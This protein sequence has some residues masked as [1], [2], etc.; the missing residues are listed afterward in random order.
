MHFFRYIFLTLLY[1]GDLSALTL[2]PHYETQG[3]DIHAS[4]IYKDVPKDF[5]LF[6]YD[7]NEYIYHSNQTEISQI[8]K[9]HGLTLKFDGARYIT[10]Q[11]K[12]TIDLQPIIKLL[13]Q[14]FTSKYPNINIKALKVFPRAYLTSLPK[15]YSLKLQRQNLYQNHSTFA[16]VTP[17]HKMYFFDYTLDATLN[18]IVTT[19]KIQRHEQLGVSNTREKNV[20]FLNFKGMPLCDTTNHQYQSKF[21]LKSDYI[22]TQNDVEALSVVHRND[23]VNA[24]IEDG[25]VS[26]SFEAVAEED[27]KVGDTITIR[28]QNGKELRAK[29]V[30][31]NR[32]EIE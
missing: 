21:S 16:I 9:K 31:M 1:I 3:R 14:E 32:V 13:T 12:S 15:E 25:R 28:K 10:F 18:V 4:E 22:L 17:D 8:F 11:Q 20:Q 2:Q 29:V 24:F 27:G 6:S 26:I 5:I 23:T 30:D 19:K 7:D